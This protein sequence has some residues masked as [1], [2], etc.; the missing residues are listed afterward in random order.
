M[1]AG[2]AAW[3]AVVTFSSKRAKPLFPYPRTEA[4][5]SPRGEAFSW[6]FMV[7]QIK[8]RT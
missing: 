8:K 1:S 3:L 2:I 5:H 6:P 4:D 7:F